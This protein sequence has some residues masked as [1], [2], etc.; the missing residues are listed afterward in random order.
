MYLVLDVGGLGLRLGG[1]AVMVRVG[2]RVG[3]RRQN[4][5]TSSEVYMHITLSGLDLDLTLTLTLTLIVN[6]RP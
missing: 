2:G 6:H 1:Y 5:I 4:V 3:F